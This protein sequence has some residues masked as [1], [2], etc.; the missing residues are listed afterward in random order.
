MSPWWHNSSKKAKKMRKN[1]A[2]LGGIFGI[3]RQKLKDLSEFK[4]KSS[5]RRSEIASEVEFTFQVSSSILAEQSQNVDERPNS[6][7]LPFP[8]NASGTGRVAPRSVGHNEGS[9]E[10]VFP[11]LN[12]DHARNGHD[13]DNVEGKLVTNSAFSDGGGE[14]DDS[15]GFRHTSSPQECNYQTST[16]SPSSHVITTQEKREKP[17]QL[18]NL[19]TPQS[20]GFCS[21][22]DNSRSSP[23]KSPKRVVGPEPDQNDFWAMRPSADP[24]FLGPGPSSSPG[25][26]HTSQL[27]PQNRICTPEHV[28]PTPSLRM[29]SQRI[30]SGP[31]SADPGFL[32]PDA[33]S[34]P[35]SGYNS[36]QNCRRTPEHYSPTPSTSSR[37][38]SGPPFADPGFLG[39]GPS[40]SP[41]SG[42]NSSENC[43]RTPERGSPTPP[44]PSPRKQSGPPFADLGFLGTGTS[45][46]PGSGYNSSQNCRRTPECGSPT[47]SPSMTS[48][49]PSPRKQSGPPFADPGFL[50]P[51]PSSSSGSGYNPSE[52]CR[53]TPEGGSP[54]PSPSMTSRAP[55]PRKQSG[56]PFADPGFL[57]PGPSSSSG[58][59]YNWSENCRRTPEGGSP[60]PSPRMTIPGPSPRK[61]SGPPFADPG[62]LGP[63]PSCSPGSGYSSSQDC[64]RTP[65][66]GLPAPSP[67]M[68]SPGLSP[69]KQSGPPFADPGLLGPGTSSSP[70]S[71]YNLSENCRRT[72]E[73]GS[74]APSPRMSIPG[75]SPRIQSGPPSVDP[76]FLGPGPS[77]SPGSGYNSSQNC[78]RTHERGSPTLSPRMTG[79]G[80]SQRIQSGP[81]SVDPGFLG[82]GPSSSSGSGYI[83]SRCTPERGSPTPSPG[84]S[85]RRHISPPSANWPDDA[86]NG[87]WEAHPL[88]LP[89]GAISNT[90][91]SSPVY[92]PRTTP[93]VPRSPGR[94]DLV[95]SPGS[96]WKKGKL[97]G[98]GAYG[99]VFAGFD[100]ATGDLCAMKEV[101]LSV[102]KDLVSESVQQLKRDIAR[103]SRLQHPNIAQYYGF[104]TA[105]DKL[106]IYLEFVGGGSIYKILREHGVFDECIIRN[107]T[108]QIL[109]GLVYLHSKNMIHKNIKGSNILVDAKGLIKLADFGMA[110]HISEPSRAL[111][112]KGSSFWTAPELIGNAARGCSFLVDIWSLGCTIH[113]MA[114]M[115]PPWS[116]YTEAVAIFKIT[117][118]REIELPDK[119]SDEGKDFMVRCMQRDPSHRPSAA[120]L[121]DHPFVREI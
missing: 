104:D 49:G 16:S 100:S 81:P 15:S 65:E 101:T 59:G 75:P 70:G 36:S 94:A 24:G 109:E 51:S 95:V 71:G 14:C 89:P 68:T 108:R 52:N 29:T 21:A 121:L 69:R 19:Q 12:T 2:N 60:I 73:H 38:Q 45:S 18:M 80:P 56:P 31:P 64:R 4:K 111:S 113:E 102:D 54:T 20:G 46:S 114:T 83:A 25:S 93:T 1:K 99:D 84:P 27:L 118:T 76:G 110:K 8:A 77:S 90:G 34:S 39:P 106:Y 33:S 66:R 47:P 40:S 85:P 6:Y 28:S 115:K 17:K 98:R 72:P 41:G 23:S 82:P 116:D 44:S 55:S 26:G 22:P 88:P 53:R 13:R 119:L 9:S 30:Q 67:R 79:P 97:I 62:F 37:K 50:G 87:K 91:P 120:A 74:P 78:R 117:N 35:W 3:I 105:D 103:L 5:Q 112:F 57:G 63:G 42:Y 58:S 32:G 107:Y 92:S 10:F 11:V 7:P 86:L 48:R 61:Q 96:R 43:R